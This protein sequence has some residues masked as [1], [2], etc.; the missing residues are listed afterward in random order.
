LLAGLRGRGDGKWQIANR[1]I[2]DENE[3][4]EEGV[5]QLPCSTARLYASNPL[6]IARAISRR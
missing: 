4:E 1:R 2:K 5:R 3:D 6:A